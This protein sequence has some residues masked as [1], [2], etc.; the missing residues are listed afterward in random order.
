[1]LL[2]TTTSDVIRLI[3]DSTATVDVHASWADNNAGTISVGSTNTAI[4]TA[5]TTTVV[6]APASSTARTV[7]RLNIRNTS[8]ATSVTV[9][10][11][12]YNGTAFE[13]D[14]RVLGP[15]STLVF[16]EKYGFYPT[17]TGGTQTRPWYGQLAGCFGNGD[18]GDLMARVQAA[19]NVAPT[20]TNITTSIAR[21]SAFMLP[22]DLTVNRI[23][24][25][26]VGATTTVYRVALYR[27]S[28]L[29]R[30]TS[31]L[32]FTTASATWV[33]IGSA[34]A[35]SLSKDTMY[36]IAC[37]V[38]ATGTTAGCSAFGGTVAATTGQVAT[39]PASLPGSMALGSTNYMSDYQFQFAVTT[40]AL[41][42]PAATLAAQA[43]WTGGCPAF[44]LDTADV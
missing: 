6:A 25:Y 23:R 24:A 8:T 42:N 40:G 17:P 22:F 11:Q 16:D 1:M 15:G 19:G 38:N 26:G 27:M 32:A 30:L 9:T 7:N 29:A 2:L 28:D 37:S 10:V 3:T 31:E 34:L 4:S 36:F 35:V 13:L 39:V 21:C 43:A 14:E 5:T 33:S 18:P 44:W 12:L 20:P 41:P